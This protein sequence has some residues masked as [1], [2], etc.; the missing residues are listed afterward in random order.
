MRVHR[1]HIQ[2]NWV[3][4][5]QVYIYTYL[6]IFN[7]TNIVSNNSGLKNLKQG[8]MHRH[9]LRTGGQGGNACIPTFQLDH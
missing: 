1:L 8:W 4:V 7:C 2:Q 5:L 9:Q 6:L 3:Q